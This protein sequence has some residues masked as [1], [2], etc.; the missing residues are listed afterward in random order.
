MLVWLVFVAVRII[1]VGWFVHLFLFF[2]RIVVKFEW[3]FL[4]AIFNTRPPRFL[5]DILLLFS[6]MEYFSYRQLRELNPLALQYLLELLDLV[7]L[8]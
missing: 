1:I 6:Q 3:D 4:F 8:R 2:V 5:N 7:E